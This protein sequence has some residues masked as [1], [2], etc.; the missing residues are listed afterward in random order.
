M[1]EEYDTIAVGSTNGSEYIL[2][3]FSSG[4]PAGNIAPI[5]DL[6]KSEVYAVARDIGV[7]SYIQARSPLISNYA[8]ILFSIST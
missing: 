3:A 8:R 4:G 2:A 7:P 1:A 6:Y 5:I